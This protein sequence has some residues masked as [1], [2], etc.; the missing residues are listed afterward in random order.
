VTLLGDTNLLNGVCVSET[1]M[2]V[3]KG[4]V[5]KA[6]DIQGERYC[7]LLYQYGIYLS[8]HV[9]VPFFCSDLTFEQNADFCEV[10]TGFLHPGPLSID[11]FCFCRP[12][13]MH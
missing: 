1:G 8:V 7:A 9:G 2:V 11:L 10:F 13:T 4:C 12:N 6:K 5:E 3:H